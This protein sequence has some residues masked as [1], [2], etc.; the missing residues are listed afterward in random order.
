MGY[1]Q[2]SDHRGPIRPYFSF[3]SHLVSGAF[4][5][6]SNHSQSNTGSSGAVGP[7]SLCSSS[8]CASGLYHIHW[9]IV[10]A[11]ACTGTVG[12]VAFQLTWADNHGSH[13]T[14]LPMTDGTTLNVPSGLFYPQMSTLASPASGD[15]NVF[16][17]GS[18]ITYN[19]IV[20]S[21]TSGKYD[22]YVTAT[23]VQ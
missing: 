15:F 13:T 23:Q 18:T 10:Q 3:L 17:N 4:S 14:I 5:G 21:C 9:A 2:C 1:Q 20:S 8:S 22:L 6:D 16:S 12:T 7:T 19:T 11:I